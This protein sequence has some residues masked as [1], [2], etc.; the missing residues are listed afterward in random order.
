MKKGELTI[1]YVI[2]IILALLVLVVIAI[3]FRGQ[4][5]SFLDSIRG[6]SNAVDLSTSTEAL[7]SK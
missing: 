1:E 3:I 5:M 6:V 4:I 2:I 7:V